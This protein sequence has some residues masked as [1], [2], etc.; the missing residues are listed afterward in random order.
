MN[1]MHLPKKRESHRN[2][3]EYENG[4]RLGMNELEAVEGKERDIKVLPTSGVKVLIFPSSL[5]LLWD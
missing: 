4:N 1:L 2:V 5:A 3:Y